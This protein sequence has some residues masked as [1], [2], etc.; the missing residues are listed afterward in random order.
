MFVTYLSASGKVDRDVTSKDTAGLVSEEE[1][2]GP[3]LGI[4][5]HARCEAASDENEI[6]MGY[7]VNVSGGTREVN[8]SL[9]RRVREADDSSSAPK[10]V[11]EVL[12]TGT[13]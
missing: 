4:S 10:D 11:S 3:S 12:C 1:G 8:P 5:A 6:L 9:E 2:A 7:D 13:D